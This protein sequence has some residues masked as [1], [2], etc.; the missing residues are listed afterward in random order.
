M[1]I[2]I[3]VT[4]KKSRMYGMNPHCNIRAFGNEPDQYTA[5]KSS[6]SGCG[7]DKLSDAV[8]RGLNQ[9]PWLALFLLKNEKK[10]SKLYGLRFFDNKGKR[11]V[12]WE[13]AVGVSCYREIVEALGGEVLHVDDDTWD[14]IRYDI[15]VKKKRNK[16]KVEV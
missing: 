6:T 2:D 11:N 14:F 4:W 10:L 7:F 3:R 13:G 12:S 1:R 16:A 5:V 8:A 15:P 9:I